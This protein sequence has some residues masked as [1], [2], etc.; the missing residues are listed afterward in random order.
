MIF[1]SLEFYF[2][3]EDCNIY[4]KILIFYALEKT[5]ELITSMSC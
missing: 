2:L 3:K 5:I 1:F 4:K